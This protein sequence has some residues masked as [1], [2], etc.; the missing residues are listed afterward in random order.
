[1]L[2]VSIKP[3]V[4]FTLAGFPVTNSILASWVV[5][6]LFT[7]CAIAFSLNA[8]SKT[9]RF[10][11]FIRFVISKLHSFFTPIAGKVGEQIFPILA[12][13][14]LFILL[15]NWTG[16]L[17]GYG[18]IVVRHEAKEEITHEVK[19]EKAEKAEEHASFTPI[20]RGATAD[21][22]MTFALSILAFCIIQYFGIRELKM[23]YLKKFVNLSSPLNFFIGI[24][25]IASELSKIVSFA[26]RLFGNIFAGEVLLVVIAF[27]IPVLA[28][29]PFLF[30][31]V[32]VGFIQALVFAMLTAVFTNLATTAHH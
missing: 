8:Q 5:L 9:S 22:N 14:F 11:F 16:L 25:E 4:L 28:S 6:V 27:L 15:A 13:L 23:G 30:M 12:S 1:M 21:L 32:F 24:L 2:H 19:A 17:P 26:F 20:L 29:S 31:E 10:I 7:V 3:E 18:S